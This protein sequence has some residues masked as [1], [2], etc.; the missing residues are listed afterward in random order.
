MVWL[1][2]NKGDHDCVRK[3]IIK[4]FEELEEGPIS[5]Y[6][7]KLK[8]IV[9]IQIFLSHV[10]LDRVKYYELTGYMGHNGILAQY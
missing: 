7:P 2:I 4:H 3:L 1:G 6:I 8:R 9:K 5:C 10:I